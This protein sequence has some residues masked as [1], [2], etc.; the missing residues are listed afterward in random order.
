MRISLAN[1]STSCLIFDCDRKSN[2]GFQRLVAFIQKKWHTAPAFRNPLGLL[3]IL[4]MQCGQV[5]EEKRAERD[6]E[7]LKGEVRTNSTP[8]VDPNL[9]VVKSPSDYLK[10]MT[11]AHLCYNNL[12][13]VGESVNFETE[14]WNLIS[15]L[16]EDE[17]L[18]KLVA[19][20]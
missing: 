17:I 8:W 7:I 20:F 6:A 10:T 5:S 16:L 18:A 1:L 19:S 4:M 15:S 2:L 11:S 3:A 13:F 12:L 9:S 14:T